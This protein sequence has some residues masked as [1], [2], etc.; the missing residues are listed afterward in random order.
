[1]R[2]FCQKEKKMEISEKKR[3]KMKFE[4]NGANKTDFGGWILNGIRHK[5]DQKNP[6][7][8]QG[9]CLPIS[10]ESFEGQEHL[11]HSLRKR[12]IEGNSEMMKMLR[13]ILLGCVRTPGYL[14]PAT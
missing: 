9:S 12:K 6:G 14:V 11:S 8:C 5:A 13:R 2:A 3:T 4:K 1:M 7:I 10:L